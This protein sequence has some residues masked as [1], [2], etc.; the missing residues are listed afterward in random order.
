MLLPR[1][2]YTT[3]GTK[4]MLNRVARYFRTQRSSEIS[5]LRDWLFKDDTFGY[6]NERVDLL[7]SVRYI[8]LRTQ[9][10]PHWGRLYANTPEKLDL[11]DFLS[12]LCQTRAPYDAVY[13]A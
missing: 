2:F 9:G 7:L 5:F 13:G 4:R 11:N 12:H 8:T 1:F 3:R 6:A 10:F